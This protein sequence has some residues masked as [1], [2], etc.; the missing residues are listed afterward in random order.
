ML[1]Q[2]AA[3][4]CTAG[5]ITVAI[6]AHLMEAAPALSTAIR[7]VHIALRQ[8]ARRVLTD[9]EEATRRHPPFMRQAPLWV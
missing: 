7:Q 6:Q 2:A 9:L 1:T 3:A 5:A 8:V 4:G